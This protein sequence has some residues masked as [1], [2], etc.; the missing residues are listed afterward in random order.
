MSWISL[1]TPIPA[2][3]ASNCKG[4]R[5]Q[6]VRRFFIYQEF[7]MLGLIARWG[8]NFLLTAMAMLTVAVVS[9]L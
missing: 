1:Y 9:S 7:D 8:H 4:L 2:E 5:P 6:C 3:R